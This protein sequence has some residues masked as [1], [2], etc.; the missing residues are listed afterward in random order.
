MIFKAI[1][2]KNKIAYFGICVLVK[3]INNL[4]IFCCLDIMGNLISLLWPFED[5]MCLNNLNNYTFSFFMP[6]RMIKNSEQIQLKTI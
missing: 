2:T 6:K 5:K 4:S 1:N 3:A